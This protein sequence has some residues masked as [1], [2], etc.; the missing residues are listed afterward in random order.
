MTRIVVTGA[1]GRLGRSVV[2]VLRAAGHEVHALDRTA[3]GGPLDQAIDLTD[4]ELAREALRGI[5][6]E[7]VVHLAAIAV[8]FSRPEHEIFSTNTS[9]AHG[10]LEAAV[11]AGARHVLVASSPT[12]LGYGPPTWTPDRLPLDEATP[13]APTHAYALSKVCIEETVRAFARSTPEVRF[14]SFR[15]CYV[16]SPQEWAGEPTQQGHT[17]VERLEDPALAAV[18]LFNYVDARDVG[19]FVDAW[20]ARPTPSGQTYVVGAQ[21]ALAVDSL[22]RL[23]PRFHPG[24]ADRAAVLTGTA[25]AF[26]SAKAAEEVGWT[27]RRSW[28][29]ELAPD[30]VARLTGIDAPLDGKAHT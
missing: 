28:R 21:D 25:P 7:A 24:T 29:T 14:A 18:S 4:V 19:E 8:P 16:V 10:V 22:D 20:I 23:L 17:I 1:S 6:P 2:E 3:D 30:L 26:S 27:A 9:M 5:A 11:A 12:V 15:P 13:P